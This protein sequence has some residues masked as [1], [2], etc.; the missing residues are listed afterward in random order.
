MSTKASKQVM[1]WIMSEWARGNRK[2]YFKRKLQRP[3]ID[4]YAGKQYLFGK[5]HDYTALY[6]HPSHSCDLPAIKYAH[7]LQ[8]DGPIHGSRCE[9]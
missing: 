9:S 8:L 2:S 4:N 6:K 5:Y 1:V 3:P 7:Q